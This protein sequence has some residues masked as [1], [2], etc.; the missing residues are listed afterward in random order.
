MRA[1]PLCLHSERYPRIWRTNLSSGIRQLF[2]AHKRGKTASNDAVQKTLF[3][4]VN[5]RGPGF[6]LE[7]L[8]G[9]TKTEQRKARIV[10]LA[11]DGAS[12]RAIAREVGC[13]IGTASKWRVHYAKDRVA[14]FSETGNRGPQPKYGPEAGQ[15]ILALLDEKPPV[16]IARTLGDVHEQY[17]WRFLRAQKIDLSGRKSWCESNDPD[18]VAKA[19]EIVG[20]YM[21]PPE[22]A[23]V[24]AAERPLAYR[25]VARLQAARNDDAVRR[26]SASFPGRRS[27]PGAQRALRSTSPPARSSAVIPGAAAGSSSSLS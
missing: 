17:I 12:T 5:L 22:N 14:G 19:A 9:S 23:I 11:V 25:P 10:L 13:T 16:L 21:A 4:H 18:F 6:E 26:L 8:V 3:E 2:Q 24:L 7:S 20:L 27:Q 15:R 1:T